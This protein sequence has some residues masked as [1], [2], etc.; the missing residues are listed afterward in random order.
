MASGPAETVVT[1]LP[2]FAQLRGGGHQTRDVVFTPDDSKMLISV[3]S[4]SNL[5]N[6]DTTPNEFHRA[7]VLRVHSRGQVPR[8]LRLRD[9]Q[10]RWGSDQ[11]HHGGNSG[12]P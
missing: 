8:G 3:G 7:D 10:L 2:G 4:A 1:Q 12:A 5:D 9:S 11:P 6:P